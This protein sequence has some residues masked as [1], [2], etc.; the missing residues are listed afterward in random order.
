MSRLMYATHIAAPHSVTRRRRS[1]PSSPDSSPDQ[2]PI[3]SGLSSGAA[4]T[5]RATDRTA[6]VPEALSSAPGCTAGRSVKVQR[7]RTAHAE[8]IV[9]GP[10]GDPGRSQASVPR[11]EQPDHIGAGGP[12]PLQVDRQ[13]RMARHGER[14]DQGISP[15]E[16]ALDL[17]EFL[18][19]AGEEP[20]GDVS[21]H[22]NREDALASG[23]RDIEPGWGQLSRIRRFG[24]GDRRSDRPLPGH[25]AAV[26]LLRRSECRPQHG[27]RLAL[28]CGRGVTQ[29]DDHLLLH[30]VA[31]IAVV[32]ESG[33][34]GNPDAVAG[35]RNSSPR[36]S[37][38]SENA[39]A[40]T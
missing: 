30:L 23:R 24:T 36:D 22:G 32:F 33:I 31:G 29:D 27:E 10:D 2:K 37:P 18:A 26:T 6:A 17:S 12:D 7:G 11:R 34:L 5:A 8:M 4:E 39:S 1:D 13:H 25:G 38:V 3:S 20:V 35:R 19:A 16:R 28:G 9:M 21:I 14:S 40:R 15:V